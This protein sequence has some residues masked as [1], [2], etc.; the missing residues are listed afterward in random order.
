VFQNNGTNFNQLSTANWS[1]I[2][3][4]LAFQALISAGNAGEN[5]PSRAPSSSAGALDVTARTATAFRGEVGLRSDKVF[6]VDNG[7]SAEPIRQI[8]LCP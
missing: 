1:T 8:R 5:R 6:A 2:A 3:Q 7:C 4:D